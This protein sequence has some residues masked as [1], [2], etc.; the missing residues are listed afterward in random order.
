MQQLYEYII[1]LKTIEDAQAFYND[2]ETP[3]GDQYIPGRA[4]DCVNR[5]PTS[6]NTHYMLTNE[7]VALIRQDPR[8]LEVSIHPSYLGITAN[9]ES[10]RTS[11]AWNKSSATSSSMKN[12]GLLRGVSQ[13]Q[14]V[15]WGSN[16]TTSISATFD[17]APTGR[18]VDMIAVDGD[19][20]LP[21]HP[22]FAVNA[23]GTGGTRCVNYN[24]YKHNPA[25]TGASSGTYINS[26]GEYHAIHVLGTMAGNTQGW[27]S[28][29]NL[30]NLYYYA[31][32]IGD[33]TFPYVM[34]YVSQFH[35]NKPINPVTGRKNPTI[36]NNSWGMSLFAS[37]W[38]FSDI[39]AVTYRG[40]RTV[41]PVGTPTYTGLT[42][43][44]SSS[45][46]IAS[47][48]TPTLVN[49]SQRITSTG[50]TA[51][52]TS[53]ST[54]TYWLGS[55]STLASATTP[56]IGDNDDGFWNL[57][58]PFNVTYLGTSYGSI[59]P[60]TNGYMTFSTGSTVFSVTTSTPALP[61]IMISS[62]DNSVQRIY[63][64][65]EGEGAATYTVTNDGTTSYLINSAPN[66]I[67]TLQKGGTYTFNVSTFDGEGG[68]PF[69]I[70]TS[71]VTGTSSSY[72]T[73]V[74]NNGTE[75]GT[76]TFTVPNN[77]PSTLYYICQYNDLM[78][79]IINIVDGS[80]TYRIIL[81]GNA[82]TTGAL[83]SP[84]IVTQY[85]LYEN[86]PEQVDIALVKNNK[87]TSSG[88]GFTAGQLNSW[89]FI[90]GQRLPVRVGPLDA[91]LEDCFKQGIIS[92]G[93]AGNGQWKHEVPGGP[94]WDNTFEMASRYPVSVSNPYYYMRGTSPTASDNRTVG[95]YNLNNISVGAIGTTST[96]F[97][98][99]YSDCGG[100]VDIWAPGSSIM[101][102]WNSSGAAT[103]V[104]DSR[105][106]S[107]NLAKISGTSM[108][109][110][111][112]C[113]VLGCILELY[114]HWNQDQAK[115]Y[116]TGIAKQGQISAGSG[117]P[118]DQ[119]DLQGSPNL[120]FA[121]KQERPEIGQ[122][123]PKIDNSPRPAGG[124][125]WP[126]PRIVRG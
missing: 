16:G 68:L 118:T 27:A 70:K 84:G 42:G 112:V 119:T 43:V 39:T 87:F 15:N 100:G 38:S 66:P 31:G 124:A 18:N 86:I 57:T 58:L 54:G 17:I 79:G 125:V 104:A 85:T 69:W 23:D 10:I 5:R 76:I 94:D 46:R 11:T 7:E 103:F 25:V 19:G 78:T 73:G 123:V 22:E 109:S 35:L 72:D 14:I 91:D 20:F 45:T 48:T 77:A 120:F 24:W 28:D 12:W 83:N 13:A 122:T 64:G 116:I 93:A 2:M 51:T 21:G 90:S 36:M 49:I 107:Y 102:A 40:T 95:F 74:T 55:T 33:T 111:Q 32:A 29:A 81:E 114:P 1:T 53:L 3:G 34:N 6:R 115:L 75:N 60:S 63:Y 71:Q 97:K 62:A 96:D 126:R 50:T 37:D 98:A 65:V 8:V 101:S 99:S 113:G 30:Y 80:R 121:F 88:G 52:V 108:A 56:T 4:V 61:K 9:T 117:G 92:V 47:F 110:P 59:F 106:A 26:S 67:L 82:S 105:N 89:G 41:A 44:F